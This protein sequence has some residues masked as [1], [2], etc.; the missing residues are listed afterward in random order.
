MT[1]SL[2]KEFQIDQK[3]EREIANLLEICFPDFDHYCKH[4][5]KQ[6]PHY[7]LLLREQDL[8]IGQLGIDYRIMNLSGQLIRVFGVIALVVHP[9]C[10]GK[11]LGT[12]LMNEFD[13][14]AQEHSD[15]IDFTF[16]LTDK[17]EFYDRL[18]YKKANVTTTWLK[19]DQGKNYGI[20]H[21]LI[22]D[23]FIMYKQIGSKS[24]T[25]GT[26]DLLGYMY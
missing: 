6:F 20:G 15:R 12:K 24:W 8:L 13:R 11:G 7:R 19:I 17:P 23:S 26:L 5:F 4:Y 21:E 14:I 1:I 9:D 3:T 10:Q 18:G 16:L 2:I 22:N 25:D